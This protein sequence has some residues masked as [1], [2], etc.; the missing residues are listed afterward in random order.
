M[1]LILYWNEPMGGCFTLH[2]LE[3]ALRYTECE[4]RAG[5]LRHFRCQ[6]RSDGEPGLVGDGG[7]PVYL[8]HRELL[9]GMCST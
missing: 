7:L 6:V 5:L 8:A 9:R 3:F 1:P 2:G 4:W